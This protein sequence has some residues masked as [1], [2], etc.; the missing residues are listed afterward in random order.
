MNGYLE[1]AMSE[2]LNSNLNLNH[3]FCFSSLHKD[4]VNDH[5]SQSSNFKMYLSKTLLFKSELLTGFYQIFTR[6]YTF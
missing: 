2:T 4:T 3:R 5:P 1:Q 6:T